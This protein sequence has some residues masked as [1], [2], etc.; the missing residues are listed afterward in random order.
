MSDEYGVD[1]DEVYKVIDAADV[2]VV[3]FHIVQK[4]L[5]IDFRTQPGVG[6][7]IAMV[8]PASSVEERFR[9]IKELRPDFPLPERVMSFQWPRMIGVLLASGVWQRM[10]DRVGVAGG[11]DAVDD[12]ARV[13]D[14]L[15]AEER[16]EVQ[17]AIRGADHYQTLWQRPGA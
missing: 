3:R 7:L 6:P 13:M 15:L 5:L 17:N 8:D 12:C 16:R 14:Q 2:L 9:A 11:A 10:V 1:L 4:R